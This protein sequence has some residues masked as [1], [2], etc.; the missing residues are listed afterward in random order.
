MVQ[1]NRYKQ[2][3]EGKHI[4]TIQNPFGRAF[5]RKL[6]SK[7]HPKVM[8][9]KLFGFFFLLKFNLHIFESASVL[10]DAH[11]FEMIQWK[12]TQRHW[13][14]RHKIE[15]FIVL[16]PTSPANRT[17]TQENNER[18]KANAFPKKKTKKFV[19][20]I[21][22]VVDRICTVSHSLIHALRLD[23]VF[24]VVCRTYIVL[25]LYKQLHNYTFEC[26]TCAFAS[27][28]NRAVEFLLRCF[29]SESRKNKKKLKRKTK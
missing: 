20:W 9:N 3:I 2:R 18:N 10:S 23:N 5:A 15:K 11:F 6:N 4:F 25:W 22:Y 12:F 29:E 28:W 13:I 16:S 27:P 21:R 14:W 26:Y 24:G 19:Q 17:T 1:L 8:H 7:S